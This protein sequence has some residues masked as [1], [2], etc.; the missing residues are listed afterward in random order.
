M[1]IVYLSL[2]SNVGEREDN[3]KN[4]LMLIEEIG[5]IKKVSPLYQTEPVGIKD[6]PWFLNCVIEV[7]TLSKPNELIVFVQKIEHK[8]GRTNTIKNGPRTI[9]IDIL[10]YDDICVENENLIVPHPR[11]HERLFVLVPFMDVNPD[12]HHPRF[13]KTIQQL[14]DSI[15]H[16]ETVTLYKS[17]WF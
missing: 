13:K 16:E 5:E 3:I 4:A 15:L 11:L 6:Q 1:S 8:L 14:Y 7:Q 17:T 12:V 9:D 10:L 2:G